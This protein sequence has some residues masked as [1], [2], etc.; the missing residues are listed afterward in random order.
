MSSDPVPHREV[1]L[2]SVFPPLF[3]SCTALSRTKE[4]STNSCSISSKETFA[5]PPSLKVIW[6]IKHLLKAWKSDCFEN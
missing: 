4:S 2:P 3:S 5:F 1:F 6:G